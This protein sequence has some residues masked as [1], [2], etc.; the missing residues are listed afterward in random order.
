MARTC[1]ISE[2]E[3]KPTDRVYCVCRAYRKY[4]CSNNSGFVL[5]DIAL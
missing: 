4:K 3:L 1:Q 5:R 2:I